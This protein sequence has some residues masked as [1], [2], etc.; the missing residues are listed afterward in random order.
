MVAASSS[1][2]HREQLR[3]RSTLRGGHVHRVLDRDD[4]RLTRCSASSACRKSSTR[5]ASRSTFQIDDGVVPPGLPS[6][7]RQPGSVLG[8]V[9]GGGHPVV[10]EVAD[11]L[12][13]RGLAYCSAA[14]TWR[15]I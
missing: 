6:S 14:S 13:A 11:D 4:A 2:E 10:A 7:S 12:P 15:S 9:V 1:A 8:R 3:E 5:R